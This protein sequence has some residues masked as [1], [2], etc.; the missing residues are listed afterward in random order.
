LE[1]RG[2]LQRRAGVGLSLDGQ[3]GIEQ[4]ES[5]SDLPVDDLPPGVGHEAAPGVFGAPL[6]LPGRLELH[7]LSQDGQE[8]FR[9]K[10][11]LTQLHYVSRR[12]RAVLGHPRG[13]RRGQ[14]G[15]ELG[16]ASGV[17]V[18]AHPASVRAL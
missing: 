1:H 9:S 12:G 15:A 8:L 13:H 11:D 16:P 2:V 6:H 3:S 10:L 5:G 4:R 18:L 17:L 7:L 14:L